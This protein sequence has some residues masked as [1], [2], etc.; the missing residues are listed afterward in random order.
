MLE[1]V[2]VLV[3]GEGHHHPHCAG[4]GG[5]HQRVAASRNERCLGQADDRLSNVCD[6][7]ALSL[8]PGPAEQSSIPEAFGARRIF[9]HVVVGAL[10]QPDQREVSKLVRDCHC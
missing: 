1:E 2:V 7:N 5:V 8:L 4:Q 3:A 9:L 6:R 10:R